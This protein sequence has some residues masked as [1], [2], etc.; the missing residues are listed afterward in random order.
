MAQQISSHS[1]ANVESQS[2]GTVKVSSH[3]AAGMSHGTAGMSHGTAG[4][5]HGTAG[6]SHGTAGMSHGTANVSNH[7]SDMTRLMKHGWHSTRQV[8]EA[9]VMAQQILVFGTLFRISVKRLACTF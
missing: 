8:S 4:M 9:R 3:G 5:S 1:T 6:M 2:H 7:V